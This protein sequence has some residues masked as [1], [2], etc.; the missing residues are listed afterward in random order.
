MPKKS[1]EDP[2]IPWYHVLLLYLSYIVFLVACY[3][4]EIFGTKSFVTEPGYAPLFRDWESF[5]TRHCYRRISDC[6]NRPV[7][8]V[9]GSKIGVKD[10][11]SH[12]GGET[13]MDTG[14]IYDCLN[15][16]S[17]NYLGFSDKQGPCLESVQA[18]IR[19]YG[20]STTGTKSQIGTTV[21]HKQVEKKNGSVSRHGRLYYF[22]HGIFYQCLY[23]PRLG[24]QGKSY[25]Q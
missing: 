18:T 9:P 11:I 3:I 13:H 21:L 16:S 5:W 17:Y 6:W 23:Y 7:V 25:Y 10:R 2:D 12:D 22:W 19:K 8:T 15:L 1:R 4:Q 24:L 20:I 14:K